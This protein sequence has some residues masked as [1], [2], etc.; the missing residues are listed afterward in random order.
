MQFERYSDKAS[1]SGQSLK[2]TCPLK[3]TENMLYKAYHPSVKETGN[4]YNEY[5]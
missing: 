1:G 5:A 3:D 4:M 2:C